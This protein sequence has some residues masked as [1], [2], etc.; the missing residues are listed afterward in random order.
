MPL[1]LRPLNQFQSDLVSEK[2][3]MQA[4]FLKLCSFIL[5]YTVRFAQ[6]SFNISDERSNLFD[7]KPMS[8]DKAY[9]GERRKNVV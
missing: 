9:N 2:Q 3:K 6:T 1:S 8:P 5:T 4:A 7:I